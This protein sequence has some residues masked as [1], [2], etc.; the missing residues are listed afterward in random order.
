MYF[1]IFTLTLQDL[2]PAWDVKLEEGEEVPLQ[3]PPL[4]APPAPP[5]VLG[6][7]MPIPEVAGDREG[8]L[9]EEEALRV[10]YPPPNSPPPVLPLALTCPEGA[11]PEMIRS[12]RSTIM[13]VS[14]TIYMIYTPGG[15]GCL[16]ITHTT[17]L[18]ALL[19]PFRRRW[20]RWP[21]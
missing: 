1:N 10:R 8:V 12:L 3:A 7:L 4:D 13:K 21:S 5:P 16:T 19:L 17:I 9:G 11:T 6:T 2:Q 14:I 15:G 20:S 18:T